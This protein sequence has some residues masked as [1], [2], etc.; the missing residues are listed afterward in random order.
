MSGGP[1]N[2][3]YPDPT[4]IDRVID[5]LKQRGIRWKLIYIIMKPATY[6][7]KVGPYSLIREIG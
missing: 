4:Y 6:L 3:G 5:E 7:K 2:Y 1:D